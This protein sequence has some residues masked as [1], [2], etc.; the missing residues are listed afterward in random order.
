MKK[1]NVPSIYILAFFRSQSKVVQR[2]FGL[3]GGKGGGKGDRGSSWRV[4][5]S[6]WLTDY[7]A[8]RRFFGGILGVLGLDEYGFSWGGA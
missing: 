1:I 7:F 6:F 4:I 2:M 5:D 3:M 8:H